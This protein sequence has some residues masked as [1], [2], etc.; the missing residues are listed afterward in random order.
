MTFVADDEDFNLHMHDAESI[1]ATAKNANAV[2]DQDK[3]YLDAYQQ[4]SGAGGARYPA[5]TQ[6]VEDE[7]YNGTLLFNYTGHGGFRRLAEEVVLDQDVIN[8]LNNP[9]KLPLFVTA[10]CDFAPYDD[11]R[12]HSIGEDILLREKTGAI[13]LMTT[14]RLVFAFSNRIMNQNYLQTALVKKNDG[15]YRTLGEA[16]K[17]AKNFT[18]QTFADIINNRKFTLLG[19]PALRISFPQFSVSTATVNGKPVPNVDT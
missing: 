10:T 3:I 7:I 19:D 9:N 15:T 8:R 5:A 12:I 4:V 17:E 16:V 14:T 1:S 13:A 11:P 2:Y 18:Y 6:A